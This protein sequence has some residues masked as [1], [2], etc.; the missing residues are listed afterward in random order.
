MIFRKWGGWSKVLRNFSEN[1]SAL[2]APPVPRLSICLPYIVCGA[3][4][5]WSWHGWESCSCESKSSSYEGK[6]GSYGGKKVFFEKQE[7]LPIQRRRPCHTP[8]QVKLIS[9]RWSNNHRI[10]VQPNV[11]L[12]LFHQREPIPLRRQIV[13]AGQTSKCFFLAQEQVAIVPERRGVPL[14]SFMMLD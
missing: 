7:Q 6:C 13:R 1:S 14:S 3:H 11:S 4:Y 10:E 5:I 12:H 9:K 2:E 8:V